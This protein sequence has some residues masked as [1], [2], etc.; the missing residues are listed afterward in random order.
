MNFFSRNNGT[1]NNFNSSRLRCRR[2]F[3]ST[4]GTLCQ[5]CLFVLVYYLIITFKHLTLV[6]NVT[7][8]IVSFF[9]SFILISVVLGRRS[10]RQKFRRKCRRSFLSCRSLTALRTQRRFSGTNALILFLTACAPL[11]L[12]TLSVWSTMLSVFISS[13]IFNIA[14]SA[15]RRKFRTVYVGNKPSDLDITLVVGIGFYVLFRRHGFIRNVFLHFLRF[16]T[17]SFVFGFR[18]FF[19]NLFDFNLAILFCRIFGNCLCYFRRFGSIFLCLLFRFICLGL[20]FILVDGNGINGI[21]LRCYLF[22]DIFFNRNNF[23][24]CFFF[25]VFD[26]YFFLNGNFNSLKFFLKL[27]LL[28]LNSR[29]DIVQFLSGLF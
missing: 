27:I 3:F 8:F 6:D 22:N 20:G 26:Y 1:V 7:L 16:V 24:F 9:R 23:F 15:R 2:L 28:F 21:D 5:Q 12:I 10:L 19:F 11:T 14:L 13:G 4:S 18:S 17:D 25:L 29:I